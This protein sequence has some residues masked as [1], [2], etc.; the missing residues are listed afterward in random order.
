MIS[1]ATNA[2][3]RFFEMIQH[4]IPPSVSL[5][6]H[7]C[8]VL[9]MSD[10]S[11]YRRMKGQI[12]LTM[13]QIILLCNMFNI[14]FDLMLNLKGN[15]VTF[16]FNPMS[17]EMN[18]RN[19]ILG[20]TNDMDILSRNKNGK[21]IYAA[22]DIPLF[23]NFA[24]PEL[25]KFKAFYWLKSVMNVE[26]LQG[27]KF[28]SGLVS[29]EL[30]A[31]GKQL[32]DI[33]AKIPSIE[34]WTEITPV[35]LFKQIEFFY[36]S[37]LFES[38]E[39]A[40]IIC[41]AVWQLFDLLKKSATL[42]CKFD[43]NQKMVESELNYQLYLSE[44]EIGNNCILT[45]MEGFKTSYLAFNTLNKLTTRD[46][47]F[48]GEIDRWLTNLISKSNPLSGVAEKRRSQFFKIINDRLECTRKKIENGGV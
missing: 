23:Y 9:K 10:N 39:D 30:L 42:G 43:S 13:D 47:R 33:Y 12:P 18:F 1:T 32:F 28:N 3:A 8:E 7:L 36:E 2:Q 15:S 37:D 24:I 6:D 40:L 35:S 17:S 5:I 48:C 20:I 41:D 21:A 29:E 38:K 4:S 26:A 19:Y 46:Q 45:D 31:A 44:I 34:I 25:A 22:E 11:V 27:V 14:S 16:D